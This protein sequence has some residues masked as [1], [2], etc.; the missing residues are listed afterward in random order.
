MTLLRKVNFIA[1]HSS[2]LA[3]RMTKNGCMNKSLNDA[4][5]LH[6]IVIDATCKPGHHIIEARRLEVKGV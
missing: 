2:W 1:E 5:S 4:L 3:G 6:V